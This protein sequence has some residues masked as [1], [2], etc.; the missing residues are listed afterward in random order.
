MMDFKPWTA[1][2][3]FIATSIVFA[4]LIIEAG[5]RVAG[6]SSPYFYTESPRMAIRYVF[7]DQAG[8]ANKSS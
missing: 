2:L 8:D 7:A 6:F 5:L 4:L 1:R 3:L